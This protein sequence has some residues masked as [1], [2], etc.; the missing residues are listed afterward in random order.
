VADLAL[1]D[2]LMLL[3]DRLGD[4]V[5]VYIE[6]GDG[7]S[8]AGAVGHLFNVVQDLMGEPD[9]E[10]LIGHGIGQRWYMVLQQKPPNA[11]SHHGEFSFSLR[12]DVINRARHIEHPDEHADG[13]G[14]EFELCDGVRIVLAWRPEE[15]TT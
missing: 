11:G 10:A 5:A 14:I 8:I 15:P 1:D 2:A 6:L 9:A 12:P 4:R 7:R 3:N 13:G